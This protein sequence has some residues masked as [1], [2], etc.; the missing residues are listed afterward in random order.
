MTGAIW[1]IL[2]SCDQTTFESQSNLDKRNESAET[3]KPSGTTADAEAEATAE[4]ESASSPSNV[5]GVLLTC[6]PPFE[7]QQQFN[8]QC[9]VNDEKRQE[10]PK[11]ISSEEISSRWEWSV[12][13]QVVRDVR[14]VAST[15]PDWDV[16]FSV[17]ITSLS[18]DQ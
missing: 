16:A 5:T 10:I 1:A 18:Q 17:P 7:K 4:D 13:G 2:T 12:Q 8:V 9:R 3:P 11:A 14:V 6:T 15:D